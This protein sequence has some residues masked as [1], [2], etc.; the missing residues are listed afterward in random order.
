[1]L[2]N[3][4]IATAAA[5]ILTSCGTAA[6]TAGSRSSSGAIPLSG[7]RQSSVAGV[8]GNAL[9]IL[10]QRPS[11]NRG[12]AVPG[13]LTVHAPFKS[14]DVKYPANPGVTPQLSSTAVLQKIRLSV[15]GPLA[16]Q[17][18]SVRRFGDIDAIAKGRLRLLTVSP[19]RAVYE[20]KTAFSAPYSIR[21]NT[22]SSGTRTFIVDAQTGDVLMGQTNGTLVHSMHIDTLHRAQAPPNTM[23]QLPPPSVLVPGT[24]ATMP[25]S[26]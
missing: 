22:W 21:G 23:R 8:E 25:P 26:H 10:P 3:V 9:P 1:M 13:G 12:M 15:G 2:K 11:A 24:A 14:A 20:V 17:T 4:I 18:V 7:V 16:V 19:D 6:K 5:I